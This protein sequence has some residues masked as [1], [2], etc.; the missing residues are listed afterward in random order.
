[1][2]QLT[3]CTVIAYLNN[4]VKVK[5]GSGQKGILFNNHISDVNI[6]IE[7][8]VFIGQELYVLVEYK[9]GILKLFHKELLQNKDSYLE[10]HLGDMVIGRIVNTTQKGCIVELSGN[11]HFYVHGMAN[12]KKGLF[13]WTSI[14]LRGKVQIDSVLYDK[15]KEYYPNY[16]YQLSTTIKATTSKE[17]LPLVA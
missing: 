4:A 8:K 16:S 7:E 1:M 11:V 9:K 12:L 10:E 3:K 2:K 6:P 17:E 14:T 15:D 5:L 13:V